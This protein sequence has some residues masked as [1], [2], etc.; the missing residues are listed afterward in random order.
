[1]DTLASRDPVRVTL[2]VS[3][4][5]GLSLTSFWVL[6]PFL[7]AALWAVTIVIA[8]WPLMLRVESMLWGCRGLAVA[9]M[10]LLMLL[11]FIV[12]LTLALLTIV[13]HAH[14][15]VD[16]L[17]SLAT[18]AVPSP[19]HW[20]AHVPIV[21]PHL[22]AKWS[23]AAA[24]PPA[25]VAARLAPYT[26]PAIGWVV[27]MVGSLGLLMVQFLLVVLFAAILYA[28]GETAAGAAR[29]F[30]RRLAGARGEH[31]ARL[32]AQAIRSVALGIVVTALIQAG[33]AAAGLFVV[34]VPFAGMLT[35]L[36]FLLCVSQIGA[37]PV[38]ALAVFWTYWSGAG[39]WGT[40]L[41]IWSLFVISIDN[42]VRP[43]LI[44]K[45]ADLP[46]LLVFVSVAGGLLAFGVVGIFVGPAVLAVAYSLLADWINTPES[47]DGLGRRSDFPVAADLR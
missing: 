6:Q 32:A 39:G 28:S 25:E 31:S 36:V 43:I 16:W 22:A 1:M 40:A 34:G 20:L 24:V 47:G 7:P 15:I 23:D 3:F 5:A 11:G 41:L 46:L 4:V 42:V 38:L 10:T 26:R 19:P 37:G 27:R 18:S 14:D 33:L 9:V 17:Q 29:R 21:G 13:N 45:G 30:A 2:A 44:R 12:P 35:A 8:T